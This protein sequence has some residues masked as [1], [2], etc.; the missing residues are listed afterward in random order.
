[1]FILSVVRTLQEGDA[2]G[3]LKKLFGT[4]EPARPFCSAVVVAAGSARRMEGIDKILC[5]IGGVPIL[6]QALAPF[7]ASEQ[8]DEIVIVTRED[9]MVSIGNLCSQKGITK[10]RRLVKGGESRTESVLAGIGETDPQAELI[11]IH[12][13][14]RPFLTEAILE[15]TIAK[16][17]ERGAA[18]PAIPLKD[19]VKRVQDGMAAETLDRDSLAAVQTPQIFEAGL[20]KG[21]LHQAR[22]D[23]VSI[24]DDCA[25]V[26]RLGFPVCLTRGSE[27]NIKITTPADLMLGEWI[28]VRRR[29]L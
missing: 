29:G 7:Q 28:L 9:L 6:L 11:A 16:A 4:P 26:E 13:G 12:D 8:V 23:G 19:T 20:I 25:A 24:T 21:A 15:E 10:V 2:M 14:A 17:R 22:K 3:L 5:P 27:E 1:M 18:A